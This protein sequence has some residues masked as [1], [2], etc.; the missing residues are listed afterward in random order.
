MA[1]ELKPIDISEIPELLRIAKE[2]RDSG[3]PRVLRRDNKDL[4]IVTPVPPKPKRG[5][6]RSLRKADYDAFL[7]SAGG[8]KDLVDT[9]KLKRDIAESRSIP[10]RPPIEL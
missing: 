8:W 4:A 7:S 10:S 3:E 6:K 2:V 9:E 5:L 1:K